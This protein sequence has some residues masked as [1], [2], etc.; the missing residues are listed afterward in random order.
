MPTRPT[1][2]R[3]PLRARLR[4][5][6][7]YAWAL[8][9]TFR[10]TLLLAT[11]AVMLGGLLFSITPHPKNLG[12]A[13]PDTLMSLY[14]AWSALYGQALF[15]PPEVWY[16]EVLHGVYPLIGF[17]LLGEGVVRFALLMTSRRRGEREWMSVMASTF[18]DHVVLCGLGHLG[19][20]I[21]ELL[22]AEGADVVVVERDGTSRFAIEA[23]ERGNPVLIDDMRDDR[24]LN[25]AGIAH[26]RCLI[27]ATNDDMAN[28]EVALDARRINPKIRVLIRFLDQRI[29]AKIQDAFDLDEAF[30]SAALAAP[31]IARKALEAVAGRAERG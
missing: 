11:A 4:V 30:S 19:S 10:W 9:H 17:V 25:Q 2:V 20:R 13:K 3:R 8:V 21:L 29:G 7:L 14:G 27:A 26:A 1:S 5:S 6:F 28:L 15:N 12:G 23:K 24:V 16:L 22:E 31:I 18:R